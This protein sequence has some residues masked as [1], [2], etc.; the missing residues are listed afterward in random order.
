MGQEI[1]FKY[2]AN[3]QDLRAIALA[4]PGE[5]EEILMQ[6]TYYDTAE[7][8]FSKRL[9]SLRCRKEN[10]KSVYNLKKPISPTRRG[11]WESE[12]DFSD[13]FARCGDEEVIALGQKPLLPVCGASFLRK[14][15]LLSLA[16]C[17]VELA[18]DQGMLF[19]GAAT[20]PISELEVELKSGSPEAAE[21]FAQELA[22]RFNLA[23]EARS[24][25]GRALKL[26]ERTSYGL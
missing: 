15:T 21:A 24:K 16:E 6:T 22:E 11:E 20:E 25:A 23:V 5:T 2:S 3:A 19:A 8:D 26:A 18:M 17:S 9:W 1:E 10:G 7:R 13:L 4:Y 14:A 12:L